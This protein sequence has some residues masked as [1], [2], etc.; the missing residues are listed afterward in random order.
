MCYSVRKFFNIREKRK[1]RSEN[2]N[3]KRTFEAQIRR[4]EIRTRA[5][6][7]NNWFL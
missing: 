4:N 5:L 1:L 7:E 6:N 3:K 2:K